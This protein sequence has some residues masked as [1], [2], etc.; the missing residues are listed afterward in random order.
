MF[1]PNLKKED[2]IFL[3]ITTTIWKNWKVEIKNR[4]IRLRWVFIT[5]QNWWWLLKKEKQKFK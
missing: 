3:K 5:T 2:P 4:K 1:L